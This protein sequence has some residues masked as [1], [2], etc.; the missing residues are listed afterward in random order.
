MKEGQHIVYASNNSNT[1]NIGTVLYNER[2]LPSEIT[3]NAVFRYITYVL[4]A[5]QGQPSELELC[6]IGISGCPPTHYGTF[7]NTSCPKN[8]HGP[9]D[10]KSGLCTFGCSNGWSSVDCK[11]ACQPGSYGKN[12]LE[13]CS[14]NCVTSPCNHVTG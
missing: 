2:S 3:F 8:C 13:K 12:C 9:C 14:T 11:Q 10:L 5:D 4:Y 1:W 7:C 6:E